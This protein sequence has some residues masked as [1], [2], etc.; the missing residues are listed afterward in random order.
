[1]EKGLID[2]VVAATGLPETPIK[3]ELTGLLNEHGKNAEDITLDE[4]R[5]IM[6]AYLQTVMLE[7]ADESEVANNCHGRIAAN[8][9]RA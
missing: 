6:A 9:M 3:R 1:M 2:A 8:T 5:E 7:L 4:L